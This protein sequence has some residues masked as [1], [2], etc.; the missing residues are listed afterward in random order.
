MNILIVGFQRSGTTLLRR[1]I[2]LH[3]QVSCV[4]HERFLIKICKDKKHILQ[5]AKTHGVNV[6]KDNWGEKVPYYPSARKYPIVT[7]CEKWEEYFG[8]DSRILHIVR[9]PYDIALSTVKKFKNIKTVDHPLKLY[10]RIIPRSVKNIGNLRTS[11]T[12]KYEDLLL[13]PDEMMAGIYKYC[14]L[15]PDFDFHKKMKMTPNPRYQK[16]DS[17]RSLAYKNKGVNFD[18]DL[19]EIIEPLNFIGKTKYEL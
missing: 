6:E 8:D 15:D 17:S 5:Y 4:F 1:L 14:G 10:K 12:F 16:I 11:Y 19:Q 2:Q 13:N 18:C 9:H 7:Y 3:P